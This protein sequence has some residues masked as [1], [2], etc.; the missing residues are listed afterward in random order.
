LS[1]LKLSA[2]TAF[3][4]IGSAC[5]GSPA[6]SA[7]GNLDLCDFRRTFAEDFNSLSVSPWGEQGTRWIAHTP[8]AQDYGDA[9]FTDPR[10]GFPFAVKDGILSIEARKGTDGK[11]R[12]GLLASADAKTKGFAQQYGYFELRAKLPPGEGLWP[13]F[14]LKSNQTLYAPG[15][16]IEIDVFEHYG[17]APGSFQSVVHIWE[18]AKSR[19]EMHVTE[20]PPGSL[21]QDFHTYGVDV[22]PDWITFY[23]DRREIW[24]FPTPRE[25]QRPLM[26]LFDLA[27]GSG[28]PIDKTPSPSFMLVDYV[29]VFERD[30]AGRADRC[31]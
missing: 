16:A 4:A 27:M 2:I 20:V 3:I 29:H 13:Q 12:S 23:L 24:R 10:P 18:N 22:E 15:A 5:G 8:Y 31:P 14:W 30:P 17:R 9:R 28:Q 7:G 11:W 25:H 19:G 21:Y 1:R 26:I 6:A